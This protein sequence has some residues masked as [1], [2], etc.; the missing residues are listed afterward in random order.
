MNKILVSGLINIETTL[1]VK[2]FPIEYFPI[3]YPF[4]GINSSVSGVGVNI[5]KA[6][7]TLNEEVKVVSLIARDDDGERVINTFKKEGWSTE[8]ISTDLK[9]TPQSI[10]LYDPTGKRSIYCDL[11]D[12]QDKTLDEEVLEKAVED[13]SVVIAC[14]INFSRP[15]LKVAKKKGVLIATDV[16]VLSNIEDE[17]NR[18]FMENADILFLSDEQIPCESK[19]FITQ[20]KNKF[21]AKI[22]VMGQGKKGAMMYVREEDKLYTIDAVDTREVVNT[23]GAG[24]AL[25]SSFIHYYIKGNSPIE[26]LKRAEVFASY[27]IGED[28]AANGFTTEENI[29]KMY[30]ELRFNIEIE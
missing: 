5:P 30:R 11:K 10:V 9:S 8:Y 21:N 13:C 25:F 19:K 20:L 28:G 22:I 15:L 2:G 18:D 23:V 12:I 29:E 14:N 4:F 6:L 24:D 3:D 16:H 26:A 17:Y 7:S 27:K 1:K